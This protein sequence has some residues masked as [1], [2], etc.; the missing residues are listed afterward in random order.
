MAPRPDCR[1]QR[2]G[3][4]PPSP[5]PSPRGRNLKASNRA[6]VRVAWGDCRRRRPACH[7][8]SGN[9]EGPGGRS[10]MRVGRAGP[11]RPPGPGGAPPLPAAVAPVPLRGPPRGRPVCSPR[12]HAP[13]TA[14]RPAPA[15][16][17]RAPRGSA[18]A[19]PGPPPPAPTRPGPR[20]SRRAEG[21]HSPEFV[22]VCGRGLRETKERVSGRECARS[23]PGA[24]GHRGH[25]RARRRGTPRG[26]R[27][28]KPGPCDPSPYQRRSGDSVGA[29]GSCRVTGEPRRAAALPGA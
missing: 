29:R 15:G 25:R 21:T 5:T 16:A 2:R 8:G 18:P 23:P 24:A 3:L 9:P 13:R 12:T 26:S 11:R 17:P 22:H 28:G 1:G 14:P 6:T 20:A 10:R 4:R 19:P 7:G 27:G